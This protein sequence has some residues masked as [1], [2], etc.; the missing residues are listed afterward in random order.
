[1]Q[2]KTNYTVHPV[3]FDN[4][5]KTWLYTTPT[6]TNCHTSTLGQFS[7]TICQY[8]KHFSYPKLIDGKWN[9]PGCCSNSFL[10]YW[11]VRVRAISQSYNWCA[12]GVA[13]Q[14][15]PCLPL[16]PQLRVAIAWQSIALPGGGWLASV[17][18]M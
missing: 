15:I 4:N 10:W 1:M 2:S 12:C 7:Q 3:H 5:V 14:P 9:F 6:P 11:V 13:A 18:G 8:S 16:L 17:L